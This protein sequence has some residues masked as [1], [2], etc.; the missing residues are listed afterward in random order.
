MFHCDAI[1]ISALTQPRRNVIVLAAAASCHRSFTCAAYT[2]R[3]G[4]WSGPCRL[5]SAGW[6]GPLVETGREP[7]NR[8]PQNREPKIEDGAEA[9]ADLRSSTLTHQASR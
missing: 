9:F 2:R 5:V 3:G 1:I 4:G 8:K 6:Y 7:R